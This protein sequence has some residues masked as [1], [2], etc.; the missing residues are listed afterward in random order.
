MLFHFPKYFTSY[1]SLKLSYKIKTS[2]LEFRVF[3]G[4]FGQ[5]IFLLAI[6]LNREH[7]RGYFQ[8]KHKKLLKGISK[9][10]DGTF[11]ENLGF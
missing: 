4:Q 6:I 2:T 11:N 7:M 9:G 5:A 3:T 10:D 1:S 8:E